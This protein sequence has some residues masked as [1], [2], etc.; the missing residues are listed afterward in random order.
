[1]K[2]LTKTRAASYCYRFRARL[3]MADVKETLLLA[4]MAA[5]SLHGR[6]GVH[7]DGSFHLDEGARTCTIDASTEVGQDIARIFTGYLTKEFGE[8]AFHVAR[9][10]EESEE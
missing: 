1:V 7:L 9:L 5:E 3:K 8:G 4:A 2:T 10:C 6:S